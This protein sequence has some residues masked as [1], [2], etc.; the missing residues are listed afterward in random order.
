MSADHDRRAGTSG[1]MI[2][3]PIGCVFVWGSDDLAYPIAL[4]AALSRQDLHV[5]GPSWL[6]TWL[7]NNQTYTG[8]VID[9]AARLT[10]RELEA[11]LDVKML[12]RSDK[13]E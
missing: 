6:R 8:I 12:V 4:A 13:Q 7:W 3:A 10:Q 11:F 5:V 9:H 2:A 1:Q